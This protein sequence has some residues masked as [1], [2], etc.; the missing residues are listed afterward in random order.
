MIPLRPS[1]RRSAQF[2]KTADLSDLQVVVAYYF[3][4]PEIGPSGAKTTRDLNRQNDPGLRGG[5]RFQGLEFV[6]D[7]FK[8]IRIAAG[9]VRPEKQPGGFPE[10]TFGERR[11]GQRI[12]RTAKGVRGV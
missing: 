3:D 11:S 10:R 2:K 9:N 1:G 7:Q 12:D 4:R 8:V 6:V 5:R